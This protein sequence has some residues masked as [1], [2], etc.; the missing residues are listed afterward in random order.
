MWEGVAGIIFWFGESGPPGWQELR[1]MGPTSRKS[2]ILGFLT[3]Q[4][5]QPGP[6]LIHGGQL[7]LS[8]S[9]VGGCGRD[10]L[11]VWRE[12]PTRLARTAGNGTHNTQKSNFGVFNTTERQP[13]PHLIH[14]GQLILS[15]SYVGGCGRDYLLVWR[16]WPTRLART[17]GNGTHNTQKSNFGVFN[18]TERQPG[19]HL[20]HGGQLILSNSYVG[21]CGRDYLLVW[22]EWPTRLARTAGNGTHITQNSNSGDF[23]TTEKATRTSLDTWWAVDTLQ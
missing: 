18:T 21:G 1:E 4:K 19:P 23:N 17:A 20:I 13:G 22:R 11:L 15:N 8:N 14:G 7:I 9:Y 2:L 6:H 5:R 16:E 10:Y 3:P 12:W